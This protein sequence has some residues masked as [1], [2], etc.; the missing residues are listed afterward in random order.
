MARLINPFEQ[1][2]DGGGDPLFQG[3]LYFYESG[4]SSA[5]KGTFADSA[6]AIPN[7][8]P[9][10]L[11][12]DGRAPNIFGSGA[13]RVILTDKDGVQ[14]IQRDPVGGDIGITFGADW[15]A[16]QVYGSNDVVRDDGEYWVSLIPA[17]QNIR[18]STDGGSNWIRWPDDILNATIVGAAISGGT[19]DGAVIGATTPPVVDNLGSVA[20][21][22]INGGT[23]DGLSS[24]SVAPASSGNTSRYVMS[25]ADN[26]TISYYAKLKSWTVSISAEKYAAERL[27]LETT[28][29]SPV[30]SADI[31]VQIRTDSTGTI[32]TTNTQLL[33]NHFSGDSFSDTGFFL[34]QPSA[35]NMEL[36]VQAQVAG[37]TFHVQELSANNEADT[38]TYNDGAAWQAGAPTGTTVTS[39]WT[40][41]PIAPTIAGFTSSEIVYIDDEGN[42][43]GIAPTN[44]AAVIGAAWESVGPTGSGATNIVTW[45]DALPGNAKWV[46]ITIAVNATSS[47]GNV[48]GLLIHSRRTGSAAAAD[49]STAVATSRTTATGA[50]T[51]VSQNDVSFSVPVDS[52]NRFDMYL[53]PLFGTSFSA[54]AR[55]TKF[56]V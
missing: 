49:A 56:G 6:E 35:G 21:C 33:V 27:Y 32:D 43:Q 23:V 1:F 22:D 26:P 4:S 36:W 47:T 45:L 11:T 31:E 55:L 44:L 39:I 5:A 2:F 9:V 40:P 41:Q 16:T 10:I 15:I 13:Y 50:T 25:T 42:N 54:S 48:A 3:K 19:L 24:L 17:N 52:S 37:G 30:S 12:A 38:E 53:N 28:G 8:N 51:V 18:P 7:S 34:V 20:T 46:E 29:K 14:I